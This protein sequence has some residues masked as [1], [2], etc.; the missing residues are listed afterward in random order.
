[1]CLLILVLFEL[2]FNIFLIERNKNSNNRHLLMAEKEEIFIV[3]TL[4]EN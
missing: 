2:P 3:R 1:M 4:Y